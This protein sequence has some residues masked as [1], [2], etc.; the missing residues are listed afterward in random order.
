MRQIKRRGQMEANVFFM[1]VSFPLRSL[2]RRGGLSLELNAARCGAARIDR[3]QQR[4]IEEPAIPDRI[5]RYAHPETGYS[6]AA[7]TR[8]Q[9]PDPEGIAALDAS[10][11]GWTFGKAE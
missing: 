3:T 11:H 1:S 9:R 10:M 8:G 4:P 2:E 7:R 5:L 6:I